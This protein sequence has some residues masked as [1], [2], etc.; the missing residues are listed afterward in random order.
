V[1]GLKEIV[2]TP[3]AEFSVKVGVEKSPVGLIVVNRPAFK[4]VVVLVLLTDQEVGEEP[5]EGDYTKA[6]W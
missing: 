3:T 2:Y 1:N 4:G 5:H 6:S